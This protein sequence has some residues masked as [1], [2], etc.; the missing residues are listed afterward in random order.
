M[1]RVSAHRPISVDEAVRANGESFKLT[2]RA[3]MIC[4]RE[5][6]ARIQF[7]HTL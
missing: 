6:A 2:K 3:P 5:C 7:F 1:R 4:D